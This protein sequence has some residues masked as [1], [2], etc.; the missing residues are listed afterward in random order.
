MALLDSI[1]AVLGT[2]GRVVP[3][4]A[5]KAELT[6]IGRHYATEPMLL[7]DHMTGRHDAAAI[8]STG[9]EALFDFYRNLV[10][11]AVAPVR[12]DHA[13]F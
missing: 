6:R 9:T 7:L 10:G 12:G 4:L 2:A 11:G 8:P 1:F 3:A 5:D 13:R